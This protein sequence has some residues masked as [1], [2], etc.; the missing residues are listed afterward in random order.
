MRVL[1]NILRLALHWS[2][3]AGGFGMGR[4]TPLVRWTRHPQGGSL[5][6]FNTSHDRLG[7]SPCLHKQKQYS[8]KVIQRSTSWAGLLQ[9]PADTSMEILA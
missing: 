6:Y 3:S 4:V 8:P 1:R 7:V 9:C 2:S 5:L